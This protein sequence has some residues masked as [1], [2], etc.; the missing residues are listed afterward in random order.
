MAHQPSSIGRQKSNSNENDSIVES[1]NELLS[2]V[3]LAALAN[4]KN[5]L[6]IQANR[7]QCLT[8]LCADL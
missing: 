8:Y 7:I 6:F 3:Q 1:D 5:M 2:K 4:N